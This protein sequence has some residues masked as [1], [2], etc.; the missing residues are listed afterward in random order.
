MNNTIKT[1]PIL[2]LTFVMLFIN[3]IIESFLMFSEDRTLIISTQLLVNG[4]L[5]YR[6]LILNKKIV[7]HKVFALI[8]TTLI[9]FS[10]LSLFS[11]DLMLT[12]NY[13]IKF[14]LPYFYF[15]IGYNIISNKNHFDYFVKYNWLYLAYFTIYIL[16]VNA[17]GFGTALYKGGIIMGFYSLNGLYIPCFAVLITIFNLQ[18]IKSKKIR[19]LSLIFTITSILILL[20]LLKRTLLIIILLGVV[21]YFFKTLSLVRI[22]RF[23]IFLGVLL[24]LISNF[25]SVLSKSFESRENRFSEDY[26]VKEEGRFRENEMIY[27]ILENDPFKLIFGSGE[28]FNDRMYF[29]KHYDIERDAHNSF[30]RIFW[31]GG[32]VGLFIFLAFYYQQIKLFLSNY[33]L[34][35]YTKNFYLTNLFY[36]GC[37]FIILRFV[38]DFSS[39]IT[40][41][42]YNAF[43]F[44]LIGGILRIGKEYRQQFNSSKNASISIQ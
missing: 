5:F 36:F 12:I 30:I 26:D 23:S 41:L 28:V 20:L 32:F 44:L 17:L 6:T 37:V 42:S 38:N 13:L 34:A 16:I 27:K 40:Y 4:I 7:T 18:S 43:S 24:F 2:K 19:Y 31:N 25:S 39:G 9:Y 21:L 3:M 22:L 33:R 10:V 29:A 15:I 1:P 8:F 11:S 14:I 35:K